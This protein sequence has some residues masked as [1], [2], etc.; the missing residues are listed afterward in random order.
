MEPTSQQLCLMYEE[1]EESDD[2][3]TDSNYQYDTE[4]L[5]QSNKVEVDNPNKVSLSPDSLPD[6]TDLYEDNQDNP[7]M[8]EN[9]QEQI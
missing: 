8:L 5:T 6:P 7:S 9:I 3:I 4:I 1:P 2:T